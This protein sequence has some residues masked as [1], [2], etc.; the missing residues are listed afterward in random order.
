MWI[1]LAFNSFLKL[2]HLPCYV[3]CSWPL[4]LWQKNRREEL[5]K[6]KSFN[7]FSFYSRLL[8][9]KKSLG[10]HSNN[11]E[12][13]LSLIDITSKYHVTSNLTIYNIWYHKL[14]FYIKKKIDQCIAFDG[15]FID[16]NTKEVK[17]NASTK[18]HI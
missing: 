16:S 2:N 4:D 18:E 14:Y 13:T 1:L 5:S 10:V 12:N 3:S 9:S 7:L 6:T 15:N 8:Y 17:F 11:E